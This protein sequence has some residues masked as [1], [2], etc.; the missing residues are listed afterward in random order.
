MSDLPAFFKNFCADDDTNGPSFI[1]RALEDYNETE[2]IS[3]E[4]IAKTFINY[5]P[6]GH[7]FLW[8][9]PYGVSS[10]NTAFRNLKSG[11]PAPR[12]GSAE[13]NGI[14]MAEQVGGQ[15]FIDPWGMVAPSNPILAAKLAEKAASV[16][17]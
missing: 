9:G 5:V 6:D 3:C 4:D 16:T 10:E 11:V 8:W 15:I 14:M 7:G 1:I 12:S 13:Q 2:N 17:H